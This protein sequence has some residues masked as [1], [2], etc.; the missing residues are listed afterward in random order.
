MLATYTYKR[1]DDFDAFWEATLTELTN[2]PPDITLEHS[3]VYS[4][5][6]ADVY[7]TEVRS[8]GDIRL[9]GWFACPRGVDT[10]PAVLI[11][12]GYT[13]ALY[14]P[15]EWATE[16]SM[17]ALALSVRGHE[18][19]R[20]EVSPG[21]PGT[22]VYGITDKNTYIYRGIFCDAWRALDLL[23]GLPGVDPTRVAVT[24]LSQGGALAL[25]SAAKRDVAA[26]AADVP[27]LC[28]IERAVEISGVYPYEEI[29]DL[30][31]TR[32]NHKSTIRQTLRY[33]DVMGFAEEIT[34]PVLM[35]VGVED[36]KAPPELARL[37][38]EMLKGPKEWV[39]YEQAGHEGG[40]WRHDQLK[41]QWL[42]KQLSQPHG[43]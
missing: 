23:K 21:F 1:P 18:G 2:T 9:R 41:M 10:A 43:V 38:F 17:C 20:D 26:V 40:G 3:A 15:R 35:A 19:S 37:A 13:Q 30:M 7:R 14:P 39:P 34:C 11:L 27:F 32:P 8:L 36:R 4:N 12:P 6:Q 22:L 28:G 5:D 33:F 31:R 42:R 24:G 25:I 29:N 16:H